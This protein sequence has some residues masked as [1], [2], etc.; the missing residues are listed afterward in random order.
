MEHEE[1]CTGKYKLQKV[2]LDRHTQDKDVPHTHST[3][4][5]CAA[6]ETQSS[7]LT[8]TGLW[9]VSPQNKKKNKNKRL[10]LIVTLIHID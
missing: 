6:A 5:V 10:L 3:L 7:F 9:N 1:G 4:Y 2:C 8:G